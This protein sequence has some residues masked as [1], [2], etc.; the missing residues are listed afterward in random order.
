MMILMTFFSMIVLFLGKSG[1]WAVKKKKAEF[2][3]R[4]LKK[5]LLMLVPFVIIVIGLKH[6]GHRMKT[7]MEFIKENSPANVSDDKAMS[8]IKVC[9]VEN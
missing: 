2:T 9:G 4:I 1:R 5:S 3:Y 8:D 6:Q 7:I